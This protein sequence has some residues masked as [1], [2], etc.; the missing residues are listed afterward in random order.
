MDSTFNTQNWIL[1]V[2]AAAVGLKTGQQ[3]DFNVYAIDYYFTGEVTDCSPFDGG[4][5]MAMH[6]FTVGTPRFN[7]GEANL[8]P[9]IDPKAAVTLPFTTS[10]AAK[11][12]SPSQ[13]GLLFLYREAP[14]GQ[15][16]SVFIPPAA[17]P[18][19]PVPVVKKFDITKDASLDKWL[20]LQNTGDWPF[21]YAG[22]G[23]G[24]RL[25]A[26]VD[27]AGL[28]ATANVTKAE[29]KFYVDAV[30][31]LGGAANLKFYKLTKAWTEGTVTWPVPWA[32]PGGDFVSPAAGSA[33]I[34][35]TSAGGWVTVDVTDLVKA[36]LA[37]PA[38]NFGFLARVENDATLSK[39]RFRSGEYWIK[40]DRPTL[41]VTYTMP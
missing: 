33:A 22:V 3:F 29:A 5:C 40:T 25:V 31:G 20:P 26:Q 11:L 2:P 34:S 10:D 21:D 41:E 28:P 8:F 27:L 37:A 39:Y 23:E 14:I 18:P 16:S 24:I 30:S 9:T 19:P 6:T 1:T 17:P 38:T 15:E 36:W 13:T 4:K 35:K 7:V 32:M 12:A